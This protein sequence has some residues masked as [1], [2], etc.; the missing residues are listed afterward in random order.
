M[1]LIILSSKIEPQKDTLS[2]IAFASVKA[3]LRFVINQNSITQLNAIEVNIDRDY[4]KVPIEELEYFSSS[5]HSEE[6]VKKQ[7]EME[8]S[9]FEVNSKKYYGLMGTDQ[10]EHDH[11]IYD[12]ALAYLRLRPDHC[13]SLYGDTFFFLEDMEKLES[14]GGYYKD[15]CYKPIS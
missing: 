11:L 1:S 12:F 10:A 5:I 8:L 15:W 9:L 14:K 13:I 3:N 6:Y 2:N 4:G 7:F